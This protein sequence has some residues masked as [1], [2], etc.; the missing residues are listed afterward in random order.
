M[1]TTDLSCKKARMDG[2]TAVTTAAFPESWFSFY[3]NEMRQIHAITEWL[4]C[5]DE[6]MN[7]IRSL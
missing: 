2:I 7:T 1:I 4:R 3:G 5:N 6:L